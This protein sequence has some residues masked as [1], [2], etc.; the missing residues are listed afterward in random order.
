MHL[1]LRFGLRKKSLEVAREVLIPFPRE[2]EID[3]QG[4]KDFL[5]RANQN[6]RGSRRFNGPLHDGTF[7]VG[8]GVVGAKCARPRRLGA[9][10]AF[11]FG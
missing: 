9:Q 10:S 5:R 8:G 11:G 3:P 1:G 6:E 4:S 2:F 7:H